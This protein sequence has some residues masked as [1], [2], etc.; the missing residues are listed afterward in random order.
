MN[1][2]HSETRKIAL[3]HIERT[4]SG[5]NDSKNPNNLIKDINS[6]RVSVEKIVGKEFIKTLA[7][8]NSKALK[9]KYGETQSIDNRTITNFPTTQT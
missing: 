1:S 6:R 9:A 7:K 5:N 8:N 3:S 2:N 4:E